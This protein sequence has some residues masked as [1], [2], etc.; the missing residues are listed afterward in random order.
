MP[1]ATYFRSGRRDAQD[2][3]DGVGGGAGPA[4]TSTW[5]KAVR[6]MAM[7]PQELDDATPMALTA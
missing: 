6:K 1:D 3:S 7:S 4:A 2:R 5:R